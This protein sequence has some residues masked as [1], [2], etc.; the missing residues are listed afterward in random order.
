[1]LIK[2]LLMIYLI[3][4]IVLWAIFHQLASRYVNKN[5]DLKSIFYGDLYKNKKINVAN[6]ETIILAIIFVNT[7]FWFSYKNLKNFFEERRLFYGLDF[8]SA[9][10][11]IEQHKKLWSYVKL[12]MF[13]GFVIVVSSFM[14]FFL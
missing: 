7:I 6:I 5:E 1:M 13:F 11:V 10:V 8:K 14:M 12:S 3:I 2:K 9:M 4:S